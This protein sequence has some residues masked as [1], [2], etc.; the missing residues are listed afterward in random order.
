[1]THKDDEPVELGFDP[2]EMREWLTTG[3]GAD[4]AGRPDSGDAPAHLLPSAGSSASVMRNTRVP[5][6]VDAAVKA[7]ADARGISVSEWIR[8]AILGKLA[9]DYDATP[10]PVAELRLTLAAATRAL[11]RLD[12][13]RAA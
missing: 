7:Q 8:E 5:W 1:M 3:D 11:D 13:R 4:L 9:G 12:A 10:D 2:G 6:E